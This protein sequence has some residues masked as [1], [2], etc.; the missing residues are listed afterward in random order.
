MANNVICHILGMCSIN[1]SQT[2]LANQNT[3]TNQEVSTFALSEPMNGLAVV[4]SYW[5]FHLRFYSILS[6]PTVLF[7]SLHRVFR[8]FSDIFFMLFGLHYY[9]KCFWGNWF[10]RGQ[11]AYI[12]IAYWKYTWDDARISILPHAMFSIQKT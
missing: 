9:C 5:Q 1:F 6:L 12:Y 11:V 10:Q 7:E 4:I 3:G 8:Y 2:L